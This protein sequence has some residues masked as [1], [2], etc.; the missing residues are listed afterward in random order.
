MKSYVNDSYVND[1]VKSGTFPPDTV[2][3]DVKLNDF[4]N[5]CVAAVFS[6]DPVDGCDKVGLENV[7]LWF[8]NKV[9]DKDFN[10]VYQAMRSKVNY[11]VIRNFELL[12]LDNW[13]KM[14]DKLRPLLNK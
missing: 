1:L 2:L 6:G 13:N 5:E 8:L 3:E 4:C 7:S 10:A 11:D 9:M 12:K 14:N